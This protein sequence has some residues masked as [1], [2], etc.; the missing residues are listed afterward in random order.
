MNKLQA[1]SKQIGHPSNE[2]LNWRGQIVA[3]ASS[4]VNASLE[5]RTTEDAKAS[6]WMS[7]RPRKH[8]RR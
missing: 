5:K 4:S 8:S 7:R 1:F 3:G 6:N 2:P